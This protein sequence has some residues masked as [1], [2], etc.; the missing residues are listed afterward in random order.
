MKLLSFDIGIKNLSFCLFQTGEDKNEISILKW[1][2]VS[3]ADENV[4]TCIHSDSKGLCG[5]EAKFINNNDCYCSVH[6]KKYDF[7]AYNA[8]LMPSRL[9]KKKISELKIIANSY[10]IDYKENDKKQIILDSLN[11]FVKNKCLLSIT[12]MNASKTHVG[13]LARNM[14]KKLKDL[15][16]NINEIDLVIIENQLDNKMATVQGMVVQYLVTIKPDINIELVSAINKLKEYL[17]KEEQLTKMSYHERKKTSVSVCT[18]IIMEDPRF[19]EWNY[20][21][22]DKKKKSKPCN[23]LSKSCKKD[24]LTD[25]FLQGLWYL[26]NKL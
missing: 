25:C 18:N 12:K 10:N 26:K 7:I 1:D 23:I 21:F 20:L 22:S 2:N 13:T 4:L 15:S 3:L 11:S 24:D 19:I 9:S 17:P 16:E 5:K 8:D 14:V 6:S